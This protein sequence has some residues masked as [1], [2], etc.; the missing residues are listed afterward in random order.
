MYNLSCFFTFIYAFLNLGTI[1]W[2]VKKYNESTS[3]L[4]RLGFLNEIELIDEERLEASQALRDMIELCK[5]VKTSIECAAGCQDSDSEDQ[6]WSNVLS[7]G[8]ASLLSAY[9]RVC[10]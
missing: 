2:L 7:F 3:D 6:R 10:L 5:D 1:D 8:G 9:N 4:A